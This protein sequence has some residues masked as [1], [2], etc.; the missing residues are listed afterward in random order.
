[1]LTAPKS[2]ARHFGLMLAPASVGIIVVLFLILALTAIGCSSSDGLSLE[3]ALPEPA[4]MASLVL[5]SDMIA[6]GEVTSVS[7]TLQVEHVISSGPTPASNDQEDPNVTFTGSETEFLALVDDVLLD[8]GLVGEGVTITLRLVAVGEELEDEMPPYTG[9]SYLIFAGNEVPGRLV[10]TPSWTTKGLI[11]LNQPTGPVEYSNG[12]P[13]P[14]A[15]AMTQQQFLDAVAT[16]V[17]V[18]HPSPTP[19]P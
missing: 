15:T 7:G 10:Y 1:M 9:V 3:D 14:F 8:D 13:V 11:I 6:V 2:R 5:V 18:Q 17:A 19:T 16:E 4:S 12:D